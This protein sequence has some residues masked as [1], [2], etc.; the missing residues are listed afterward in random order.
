MS[1]RKR[2]RRRSYGSTPL[3]GHVVLLGDSILDNEHYVGHEPDIARLLAGL[4]GDTWKVTLLARDGATTDTLRFQA[5]QIPA[6]T[7]ELVVSIGG[8]DANRNARI[9]V[10]PNLYTMREALEELW[11]LG[12]VFALNYEEAVEPLLKL[13]LPV[14]VCTIYDCDFPEG[15]A[16]AVRAALA[17][18]NDVILRFAFLHDLPVLDLRT[19]CTG[20]EDYEHYIEPSATGGAKI[21][22]AISGRLVRAGR[23]A[24]GMVSP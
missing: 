23:H 5:E 16:E 7:T 21:A 6:D 24:K 13:G 1:R 10:D 14:T 17:I 18:F 19:V 2:W 9:L 3:D 4:L 8:N 22:R 20:P 12:S 15:E 11:F